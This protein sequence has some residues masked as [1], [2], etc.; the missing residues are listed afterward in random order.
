[1]TSHIPNDNRII[2]II[3][4]KFKFQQLKLQEST[5]GIIE[6]GHQQHYKTKNDIPP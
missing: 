3:I 1:M 2:I 4:K 6:K 5:P